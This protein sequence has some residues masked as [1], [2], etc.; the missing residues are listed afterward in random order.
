MRALLIP[1]KD[2][3]QAKQRLAPLLSPQ[4]RFELAQAMMDDVFSAVRQ[5]RAA[6]R[7][8]VVT[9]YEPAIVRA[10]RYGWTVLRE[11]HQTS[12]SA[13]VDAASRECQ[14]RGVTSLLRLPVD[15]PLVTAPDINEVLNAA[16]PAPC[17]VLVPSRDSTGTNAILRCHPTLFP[18]HFGP[19]SF[20]KHM[21][22][23]RAAGASIKTIRNPHLELDVDDPQDLNALLAEPTRGTTTGQWLEHSG[24]PERLL[25][26]AK[27]SQPTRNHI[28][29]RET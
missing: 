25:T 24:V 22:E 9:N 20:G 12:E 8:F 19:D 28:V 14:S 5:V 15:L 26:V 27:F 1:V 13:S 10:E 17:A 23:A 11:T 18:S 21:A 7:V 29:S 6:E 3:R 16:E 2:L 4:E